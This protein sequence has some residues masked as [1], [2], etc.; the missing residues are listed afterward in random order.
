MDT[1]TPPSNRT[2]ADIPTDAA[3]A[4]FAPGTDALANAAPIC[5][6][7][8][9][10]RAIIGEDFNT[11]SLAQ[12]ALAAGEVYR[13]DNALAG[14]GLTLLHD[15]TDGVPNTLIIGY[16]C[17]ENAGRYAVL[18]GELLAQQGF[19][20]LISN[21]YC[22]TPALCWSIAQNSQAV[23]GLML[24]SSHNPAR[25]LGVKLRMADGGA[26]PQD[27]SDRVEQAL[28]DARQGKARPS[29]SHPPSAPSQ[30]AQSAGLPLSE[31]A[32]GG[33]ADLPSHEP[34]ASHPHPLFALESE[35]S[36]AYQ[37][38][39]SLAQVAV[40][41]TPQN[42][43]VPLLGSHFTYVDLMD[44]YLSD[45]LS[46][47][48]VQQIAAGNLKV[49]VD[50]MFGAGRLYLAQVLRELGVEVAEVN[51]G[52]DPSFDGLHP[53]PILPW[54]QRGLDKAR[55]IGADACFITDGDADRIGAGTSQGSFVN[56]HLILTL[57]CEHL[58]TDKHLRGRVVRTLSGSNLIKRQC[59]RLG[60]ELTTTPI[61]FKWIYEQML[62][63][64]VMIGGEESGGIGIPSHVRER[65]GLLMALLLTELMAR[66]R[67]PLDTLVADLKQTLGAL[68]Y[69]RRD[70]RLTNAQKQAFVANVLKPQLALSAYEQR[71]FAI[72]ERLQ[73][74][75][76]RDGIKFNLASD[77]WLLLRASG[78]EPLVRVYAEAPC[79]KQVQ[80]L[81]NLGET[82]ARG[83]TNG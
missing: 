33:P 52:D 60:L 51:A 77:S 13:A 81:L 10:W 59:Q 16:D 64:D 39:L 71:F 46:L 75:D 38:A 55:E 11:I 23:G 30:P 73:S 2:P 76:Y 6:G 80:A 14:E 41:G 63:G 56:P 19:D 57:L 24:T 67:Q 7:T 1:S 44:P 78:T 18:V 15:H 72:G 58:S 17:R 49:V 70:L 22:P 82:V 31:P 27:F 20:V 26:S 74:L 28:L 50:S 54:V 35:M 3:L 68:E 25:Y 66:R 61:G 37:Q 36:S 53:E 8:D 43:A 48:D 29:P 12:V 40:N 69:D 21:S 65:D 62:Q 45:L 4:V 5:F 79:T 9:G 83:V 32:P 47:V 34:A 42:P